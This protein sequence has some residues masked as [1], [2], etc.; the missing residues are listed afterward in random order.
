MR[1]PPRA[2]EVA[3]ARPSKS[4]D[5]LDWDAYRREAHR[6]L[7]LALDHVAGVSGRPVWQPV[8]E[9]IK[10]AIAAPL[11]ALGQG[12]GATVE[13]AGRLILPYTVGNTHPRFFGWVHG[14][15]TA[16]GVV[17]EMLAAAMNVNAGGR[18]HAAVYVERQVIDW[19]KEIFGFPSAANGLLV[20]GTSMATLI[21]LTAARDAA[22]GAEARRTGVGGRKLVGYTSSEAHASIGKAFEMLGLGREALRSIPVDADLR[23]DT[24]QLR[25]QI[26]QDR[27][28]GFEPFAVIATA[29]TVNTGAIDPLAA[30]ARL[31]RSERLWLHV[32]GA[33]GALARLSPELAPLLSGIDKA[34]SIAFDFHKWLHVPYDAG[35]VLVRDGSRLKASFS[36]RPDY[37]QGTERGLAA[38]EPWFC[39]L[40]P[41]LSR[42]FRAFKVW[43]TLKE[44]GL[45]RLGE[46]I[47]GNCRQARLLA[48]KVRATPHL[49]LLAPVS[50][51]IVC[52]RFSKGE[53]ASLDALNSDIVVAMQEKG[54]AAPSTTRLGGKLAIRVNLT[55]HRTTDADLDILLDAVLAEGRART[56]PAAIE[57]AQVPHA[58]P[59][60]K[61]VKAKPP[62]RV[63]PAALAKLLAEPDLAPVAGQ[64]RFEIGATGEL[65]FLV[66]RDVITLSPAL[67]DQGPALR[68]A[69]RH[70]AEAALWQRLAPRRTSLAMK[71][72]IAL[73]ACRAT[74][75]EIETLPRATRAQ[76]LLA[77]PAW[78]AAAYSA[79][80]TPDRFARLDLLLGRSSESIRPLL[81]MQGLDSG[82][83][84]RFL[85]SPALRS[86]AVNLLDGVFESA[87][88]ATALVLTGGDPRIALDATTGTNGYGASPRPVAG[89]VSF[90]SSTASS[91]TP[92]GFAAV[93]ALRQRLIADA[94][95]GRLPDGLH[96]ETESLRADLRHALE[97]DGLPE[98]EIVLAA[99]GTDTTFAA[100]ALAKSGDATPLV[101][102]LLAPDET[103]S[104]IPKAA[105]GCHFLGSTSLGH[106]VTPGAPVEDLGGPGVTAEWIAI[107]KAC[108][109]PRPA[110]E[111]DEAIAERVS[112]IIRSGR[113]CL[114][115]VLDAAKSGM[116]APSHTLIERLQ[117]KHG[118]ALIVLVDA[119]QMRLGAPALRGMLARGSMVQ[120]TG[121]KFFAGPPFSGALLVPAAIARQACSGRGLPRG[122]GL[123]SGR[124]E[125][126]G[127]LRP[128]AATLPDTTNLGIL[129][130]WRA[131]LDEMT[132]FASVPEA[133]RDVTLA[134]FTSDVRRRIEAR[135]ELAL[136]DA[137]VTDRSALAPGE[138][139]ASEPTILAFTLA[140][141]RRGVQRRL[142]MEEL[143]R[144]HRWMLEDLTAILPV[145]PSE[146]EQLAAAARCHLGQ[147]VRIATEGERSIGALRLC[148]SAR[149]VTQAI[150]DGP[151]AKLPARL[152]GLIAEAGLVVDKAGLIA[153][154]YDVLARSLP[155]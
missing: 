38:G 95:A 27:A 132:R 64:C 93:E 39:E 94:L 86:D 127:R 144:V 152:A 33:F 71:A 49:E 30:I 149:V 140:T 113:R 148:A 57:I 14:T 24:R 77:L 10:H 37:L 89:E 58:K 153:R 80:S 36:T 146:S 97:L 138:G 59:S 43:F 100:L 128:L 54:I 52:F 75:S 90:A 47:A 18:D 31:A 16:G 45:T 66:R 82:E 62:A 125:W 67:L 83:I 55:N 3:A 121:S 137:P 98:T 48:G 122:L 7:D 56:A 109:T 29:G 70:A 123:Y 74:A 15:G 44:H 116:G 104:G 126:A 1:R 84:D 19:A 129:A 68:V 114:L 72:A 134:R 106:A 41:E 88:S 42:S 108:G 154:H 151:R 101:S 73:A 40:G 110:A 99:S 141:P 105:A 120:I 133:D 17:A 91:M 155:F 61:V 145:T 32:D 65:A 5:P 136:I 102:L 142:S 96:R 50:L 147:P 107:R 26:A 53:P 81:E 115:H 85:A 35:A 11:P 78:L 2:S 87:Y 60:P 6:A 23:M 12:L 131:A 150:L 124:S 112:L 118:D 76:A 9:T 111:I 139:W 117:Q 46:M 143:K 8:P 20:S 63:R 21:A 4:L 13:E 22:L 119:C 103:G 25:Q 135:P 28:Q 34:Q 51:N 92:T 79:V 69:V 130:R